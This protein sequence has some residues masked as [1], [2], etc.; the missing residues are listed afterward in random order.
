VFDV[1]RIGD[2]S[3]VLVSDLVCSGSEHLV[4]DERPLPRGCKLVSILAAL[5]LSEDQV[6]DMELARVHVALVVASQSLLI[7]A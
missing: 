3:S 5:N 2:D 7:L 1:P 6:S 4:D